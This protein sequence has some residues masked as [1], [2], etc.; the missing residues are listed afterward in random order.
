MIEFRNQILATA[1]ALLVFSVLGAALLSGTFQLTRPAIEQ[2]ERQAKLKLIAQTLPAGSFETHFTFA[3]ALTES[4]KLAKQCLVVISL[5]ASTIP[6]DVGYNLLEFD[7]ALAQPLFSQFADAELRFMHSRYT[8]I[9]ESFINPETTPPSLVGSSSD[10]YLI[11][12]DLS[13]TLRVNAIL[14]GAVWTEGSGRS[15]VRWELELKQA[16]QEIS[17]QASRNGRPFQGRAARGVA[18][19]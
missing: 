12:N 10:L 17:G 7:V 3:Q 8:S 15:K 19:C 4:A 18:L 9:I 5:P 2:S 6:V 16:F 13:L 14:P 1:S 11:A